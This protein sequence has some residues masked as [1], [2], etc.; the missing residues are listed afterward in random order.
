M[1]F[2]TTATFLLYDPNLYNIGLNH[3]A[4]YITLVYATTPNGQHYEI[5]FSSSVSHR[6]LTKKRTRQFTSHE[7]E[8]SFLPIM[9]NRVFLGKAESLWKN[10]LFHGISCAH[11]VM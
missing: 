7:G 9:V 6:K 1:C 5:G 10:H 4:A 8:Y 3:H 11:D 2:L